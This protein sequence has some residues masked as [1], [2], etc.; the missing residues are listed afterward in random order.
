[1]KKQHFYSHLIDTSVLSLELGD[2]DL[3]HEERIHLVTLVNSQLHHVIL[4]TVLSELSE[5]DKKIFLHLLL[6]DDHDKIWEHL[7]KKIDNI[8]EKIKKAV[9]D[10]KK[11]LH[12][13]I[14]E[15]HRK[16]K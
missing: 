5:H 9:E 11:E 6:V 8:E 1:M 2:M 3:T 7:N 13:D 10:L 16:S 15:A 14:Q 12:K 4:D